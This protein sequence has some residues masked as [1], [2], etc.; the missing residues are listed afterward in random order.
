MNDFDWKIYFKK[1]LKKIAVAATVSGL[2]ALL[3]Y[4][5][6]EPVPDEYVT[7]VMF[8]SVLIDMVLNALKHTV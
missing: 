3:A 2:A 5:G 6:T 4:L 7:I 1:G 8:G